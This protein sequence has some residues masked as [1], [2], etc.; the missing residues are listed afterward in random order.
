MATDL[1]P[2]VISKS[3]EKQALA[4]YYLFFGPDEFRMERILD[5][6]KNEFNKPVFAYI[7][8]RLAPPNKRMG[9]AGAIISGGTGTA[10]DKI[11]A[12]TDAGVTVIENITQVGAVVKSTLK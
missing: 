4:P 12:L 3:L 9:H 7:A 8:G 10:Q 11:A 6:I 1:Q 2:E 5:R